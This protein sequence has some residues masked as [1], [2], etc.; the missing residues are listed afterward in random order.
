MTTQEQK[1][2]EIAEI[3]AKLPKE[4]QELLLFAM[5]EGEKNPEVY[6]RMIQASKGIISYTEFTDYLIEL[7]TA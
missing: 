3:F 4:K 6:N 7:Q 1:I 5:R 2:K